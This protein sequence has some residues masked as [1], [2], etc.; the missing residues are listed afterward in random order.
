MREARYSALGTEFSV[1][2]S[3]DENSHTRVSNTQSD[4]TMGRTDGE[5][6]TQQQK[7]T[8]KVSKFHDKAKNSTEFGGDILRSK[9]TW[10][11]CSRLPVCDRKKK[12][13]R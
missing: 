6:G 10:H 7:K 9:S 2:L 4:A 11:I 13:V 3:G 1:S 12:A 5:A 8:I